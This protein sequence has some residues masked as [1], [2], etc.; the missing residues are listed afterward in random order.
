M[1]SRL[2]SRA[3]SSNWFVSGPGFALLDVVEAFL[4]QRDVS[5]RR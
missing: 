3:R 4:L 5:A 2:G 1:V